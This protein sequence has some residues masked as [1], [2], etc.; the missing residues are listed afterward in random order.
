MTSA[1]LC[2]YR[3]LDPIGKHRRKQAKTTTWVENIIIFKAWLVDKLWG[4][5]RLSWACDCANLI[6]GQS[7]AL[8]WLYLNKN[9][10]ITSLP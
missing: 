3:Y 9:K 10:K 2:L 5:V 1:R 7:G 6:I 8:L 4:T